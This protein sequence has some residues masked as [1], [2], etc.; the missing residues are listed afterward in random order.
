MLNNPKFCFKGA[1]IPKGN[2]LKELKSIPVFFVSL[3]SAYPQF[4][5]R[6]GT[7]SL[8]SA[9]KANWSTPSRHG[10]IN[11]NTRSLTEN[12]RDEALKKSV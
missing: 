1:P 3:K 4:L 11:P 6:F 8:A 5:G 7:F 2:N 10:K 12:L 9:S